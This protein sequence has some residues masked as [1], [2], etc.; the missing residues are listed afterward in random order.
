MQSNLKGVCAVGFRRIVQAP[1]K[2]EACTRLKIKLMR[3]DLT[4]SYVIQHRQK[5]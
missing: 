1:D 4:C 5:Y 2:I 3:Y